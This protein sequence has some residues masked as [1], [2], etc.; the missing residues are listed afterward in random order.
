MESYRY[1]TR[2]DL[3]TIPFILALF[4]ISL[5]VISSTTTDAIQPVFFTSHVKSQIVRI[6]IGCGIY[7]FFVY[8]DYRKL[9]QYA[10]PLYVIIAVLLIG[11]FFTTPIQNVRR[12]YRL[13]FIAFQ[14][15]EYAKLIL[16]ITLSWYLERQS[17]QTYLTTLKAG[18]LLFV[19]FCLILKQPDLGTALVL[20]PMTL[21]IFYFGGVPKL[22]IKVM[23]I[24]ALVALTFILLLFLNI[25]SH[26]RTKPVVTKFIKEYQYERLNPN[27][28]HQNSSR[29]AIALGHIA[30]SGWHKSKFTA[31]RFLPAAHTDSVFPAFTEETGLIGAVLIL[32]LFAGL[33]Y[34][35]FQVTA[36]APDSFGRLLSAGIAVYLAT[37]VVIN[38]G[39]MCGF[40]PITGVPLL[41]ITYGGSSIFSAMAA[42]GI[43]Q[44]IYARRFMF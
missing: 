21:A 28:Y 27:T 4:G 25:I 43:L 18:L 15:S 8:F 20:L 16:V 14:P 10:I 32:A 2:I 29:T 3:R 30:G 6:F 40:L 41:L 17:R 38:I 37:H 11:L 34:F 36:V 26:E 1:L 22:I 39:M 13:P 12:W 5:Y 7:L 23:S 44:S 33:I 24:M 35:S 19:P 9:R 42:L 31:R